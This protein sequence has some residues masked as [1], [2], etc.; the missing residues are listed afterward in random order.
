MVKKNRYN[1]GCGVCGATIEGYYRN[2]PPIE[3]LK[4]IWPE[5]VEGR[6]I[7]EKHFKKIRQNEELN[8]VI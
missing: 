2:P 5:A 8:Q 4:A 3:V 1:A 6:K 7:C